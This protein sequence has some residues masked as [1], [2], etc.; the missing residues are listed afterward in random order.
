MGDRLS[1]G[2]GTFYQWVENW[3]EEG[4][5][6][7]EYQDDGW[8]QPQRPLVMHP[9]RTLKFVMD[10]ESELPDRQVKQNLG[11]CGNF[12][13]SDKS[14]CKGAFISAQD[15]DVKASN[16]AVVG[17]SNKRFYFDPEP[18]LWWR[19][20]LDVDRVFWNVLV[21][22]MN[23]HHCFINQGAG[24]VGVYNE[25]REMY[26]G[27]TIMFLTPTE[28]RGNVIMKNYEF[29]MTNFKEAQ[30]NI[31][32]RKFMRKKEK[33]EYTDSLGRTRTKMVET[34]ELVKDED[35]KPIPKPAKRMQVPI[36]DLWLAHRYKRTALCI[37]FAPRR[38]PAEIYPPV[39][40]FKMPEPF[41]DLYLYDEELTPVQIEGPKRLPTE[42][43]RSWS[44]DAYNTW[45]GYHLDYAHVKKV[46]LD[47]MQND[48]ATHRRCME[49]LRHFRHHQLMLC[50]MDPQLSYYLTA[51]IAHVLRNPDLRSDVMINMSGPQG[52][53]KGVFWSVFQKIIGSQHQIMLQTEKLL[54]SEFNSWFA[55]KVL[56]VLDEFKLEKF[57][58]TELN[59]LKSLVTSPTLPVHQKFKDIYVV[60]N[61]NNIVTLS[62]PSTN[63]PVENDSRRELFLNAGRFW[64]YAKAKI[65][66]DHPGT[67][68]MGMLN[69]MALNKLRDTYFSMD[70]WL[71]HI[72]EHCPDKP[73]HK[74]LS[75]AIYYIAYFYYS[76]PHHLDRHAIPQ[77]SQMVINKL[78]FSDSVHHWWM[79]CLIREWNVQVSLAGDWIKKI[80][81]PNTLFEQFKNDT[82][83]SVNKADRRKQGDFTDEARFW[84]M[85]YQVCP[86][87]E[88]TKRGVPLYKDL[89]STKKELG[90]IHLPGLSACRDMFCS[91]FNIPESERCRVFA[92]PA[93][94][95]ADGMSQSQSQAVPYRPHVPNPRIHDQ[96]Y[97]IDSIRRKAEEERRRADQRPPTPKSPAIQH[98]EPRKR[99]R[100][101]RDDLANEDTLSLSQ[102]SQYSQDNFHARPS[103][104]DL[105][106]SSPMDSSQMLF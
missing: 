75:P 90:F 53:G 25:L 50:D 73:D 80:L 32:N 98:T 103:S 95:N 55:S 105:I 30:N 45:V 101:G 15:E 16:G 52:I 20:L 54:S 6:K 70:G 43:R 104:P 1:W 102:H 19:Q 28:L 44:D 3:F 62:N 68:S 27:P 97:G 67:Y 72:N 96:I 36:A 64:E 38:L 46:V 42:D 65:N 76:W 82:S 9:E 60:Q 13:T 86:Y 37:Q 23:Q 78:H 57:S 17:R 51:W 94:A 61:N 74:Y 18:L 5:C 100:Q 106:P 10:K 63:I 47:I 85:L 39:L 92:T 14:G 11:W 91:F 41:E 2:P 4:E 49:T 59:L 48:P 58:N 71:D 99:L 88:Q 12:P 7:P 31:D 66:M 56:V 22:Y 83:K 84:D 87:S 69:N 35:G 34:D 33:E 26:Y 40:S 79:T 93:N 21:F 89:V 24:L 81:D 77:T 8:I 29:A